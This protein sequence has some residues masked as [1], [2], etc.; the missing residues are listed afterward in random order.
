MN[1]DDIDDDEDLFADGPDVGNGIIEYEE[2]FLTKSPEDPRKSKTNAP[3]SDVS[4]L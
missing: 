1:E 4:V 3:A 2:D